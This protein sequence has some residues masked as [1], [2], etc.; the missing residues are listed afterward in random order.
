[1]APRLQLRRLLLTSPARN[2]EVRFHDGVNIVA[3]P[4]STGKSSI[5]ELVDY[6]CGAR[7]APGYPELAKCS[8]VLVELLV[9]GETLTIRRALRGAAARAMV[10]CGSLDEVLAG[11]I[12]GSEVSARHVAEER[13][14]SLEV[15]E[16]LG[17]GAYKV[18]TAATKDASETTSFSLRDLLLLIYVDQDRMGSKASFFEGDHFKQ[19]KWR[20]AF[21][22]AHGVF[23]ASLAAMADAL[24]VAQKQEQDLFRYLEN[25]RSFLDQFKV[26]PLHE[27]EVEA[28]R[29]SAELTRAKESQKQHRAGERARLGEHNELAERRNKVAEEERELSARI[30]ELRRNASQLGRLRV[31]YERELAQW[32]FLAESHALMGSV[33]VSRCPACLQ[34]VPT[35]QDPNH[36]Y[37]CKQE[38][39]KEDEEISVE[40]RLRSANRRIRDLEAYLVDLEATVAKLDTQREERVK[41]IGE[42][43]QVLHRVRASTVL[44]E[45]RA[46]VAGNELVAK[47]E[48]RVERLREQMEYRKRAQGEG[49]ALAAVSQRVRDLQEAHRL[50]VESKR[51]ASTVV[52]DLTAWYQALLS[53]IKFPALTGA[54]VDLASYRPF[55]RGQ[56]YQELSSKGA[57][58]LAVVAW[59][60]AV[61]EDALKAGSHLQFP[62]LLMLDSPLSHVGRAADD[63][64]F[65]DQKLVD[66]FY[67]VLTRLHKRASEFQVI[68]IDNRPPATANEMLAVSFTGNPASGRYGLID[69]EHLAA[70]EVVD[71]VASTD[72]ERTNS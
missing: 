4:I 25:A 55:V 42:M 53:D 22:I 30:D 10:Y 34:D 9:G 37:V 65:R 6:V 69:D 14:V 20:A 11:D 67:A 52:Q 27:L 40:R 60:L 68:V 47:L 70:P 33:P 7:N 39:Q 41:A 16:R 15:L 43:D 3:G 44:P 31:Q 66:G 50:A 2:Y 1:M 36:C 28:Q 29:E 49:S 72:P 56:P 26:P 24:R 32:K 57:I 63:P 62:L 71:V 51:S 58:S 8:D 23:D 64:E 19:N 45:T 18:K 13:S 17:L 35:I 48:K 12:Q 46:I 21:E 38:L 61:L 54:F 59:H 5:L